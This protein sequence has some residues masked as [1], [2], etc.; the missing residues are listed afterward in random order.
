LWKAKIDGWRGEEEE[1]VTDTLCSSLS[2]VCVC[3]CVYV[4][5]TESVSCAVG[6]GDIVERAKELE[7]REERRARTEKE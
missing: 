1:T 6:D 4:I 5:S 7:Q 2:A 3:V